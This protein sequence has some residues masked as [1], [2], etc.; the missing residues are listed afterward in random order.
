M[1]EYNDQNSWIGYFLIIVVILL[2][3]TIGNDFG[4]EMANPCIEFSDECDVVCYGEGT[5]AFDCYEE[6]ECLKRKFDY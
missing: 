3:F 4:Y 2:I 1:T 6:C 5:P